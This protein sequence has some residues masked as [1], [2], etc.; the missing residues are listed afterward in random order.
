MTFMRKFET[1]LIKSSNNICKISSENGIALDIY[2]KNFNLLSHKKLIKGFFSF[3][4][5]WFNIDKKDGLY[6]LINDKGGSLLYFYITDEYIVK[7]KIYSY[8]PDSTFIKFVYINSRSEYTN[9]FY[10]ISNTNDPYNTQLIHHF[11]KN[12][13]W[14]TA[15][16]DYLSYNVL[17]NFVVT[18]AS[19][20]TPEIFYYKIIDGIEELFVSF[21]DID[22]LTWKTP[23]QV[24]HSKKSKIYLSVIKDSSNCYH[25]LF[26]ENNL[27][28]Y[29]CTYI[30]G[31]VDNNNFN[32]KNSTIISNT[33]ACTFP[34]IVKYDSKL[35]AHWIEYH[36]LYV[37]RSDNYGFSWNEVFIHEPS[38]NCPFNC[39]N[40]HDNMIQNQVFNYFTLFMKENSYEILGIN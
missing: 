23:V 8:N 2:D 7:K 36:N 17:T 4:D 32:I 21:F 24:T 31:C 38:S 16:V 34:N 40:Y 6:G 35:Y 33:V 5:Y 11:K 37:C 14:Y 28:R 15:T 29:H 39:C 1:V 25:I 27:S 10:Y 26:S 18:Y 30:K 20:N 19:D 22:S 9:I 12:N 13:K 3:L